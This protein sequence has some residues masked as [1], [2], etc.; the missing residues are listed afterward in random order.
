[1]RKKG[2]YTVKSGYKL[3]T[4][5][6]MVNNNI[7]GSTDQKM[8]KR[9]WG[10]SLPRKIHVFLWRILHGILPVNVNLERKKI[11]VEKTC[12]RCLN[13][14]ETSY[15]ALQGCKAAADVWNQLQWDW[16]KDQT[17]YMEMSSWLVNNMVIFN[18]E[19]TQQAAI[20]I[21]TIWNGRNGERQGEPKRP[22]AMS[23]CFVK[24]FLEEYNNAQVKNNLISRVISSH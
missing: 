9:I 14:D 7:G 5:A 16:D 2:A 8:W 13:A 3:L 22:A 1:M 15:H 6:Y 24:R 12:S 21:W 23:A 20:T 18:Q 17:E 4:K 19:Q 11:M 10:T